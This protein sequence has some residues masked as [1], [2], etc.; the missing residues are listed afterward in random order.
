MK[1]VT[2]TKLPITTA[3]DPNK[4]LESL[5]VVSPVETK[6]EVKA[7]EAKVEVKAETAEE[8][9]KK[10]E[11]Y[12]E[13]PHCK[14]SF[15]LAEEADAEED[16]EKMEKKAEDSNDDDNDDDDKDADEED[17]E[18]AVPQKMQLTQEGF[19][20]ALGYR[21]TKKADA[22]KQIINDIMVKNSGM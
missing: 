5:G 14:K 13:C 1:S 8:E 20:S 2:I 17:E 15:K 9:E 19:I 21:P 16:E 22:W 3:E 11:D 10:S 7:E 6:A 12:I 4:K 18:K